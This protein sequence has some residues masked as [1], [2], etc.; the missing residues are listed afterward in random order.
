MVCTRAGY[1]GKSRGVKQRLM[2]LLNLNNKQKLGYSQLKTS[3]L[4]TCMKLHPDTSSST[5]AMNKEKFMEVQLAWKEYEK[6]AKSMIRIKKKNHNNSTEENGKQ[7]L[8]SMP[9][10][11][12]G[13]TLFGVGC[14]FSDNEYEKTLRNSIMNQACRGWF[15]LGE[16]PQ[17]NSSAEEK[18]TVTTHLNNT[19]ISLCDDD[20]FVIDEKSTHVSNPE[21]SGKSDKKN[22]RS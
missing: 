6:M 4:E 19:K 15:S 2:R 11:D 5:S 10:F 13:F 1:A 9:D 17:N 21:N 20:M 14:S 18:K 16:L 22:W 3:Y 12:Q 7:S 8:E